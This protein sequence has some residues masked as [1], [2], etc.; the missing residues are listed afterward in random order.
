M[1]S[2]SGVHPIETLYQLLDHFGLYPLGVV[3]ITRHIEGTAFFPGGSGLW[4]H[5]QGLH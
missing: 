2:E 3:P 4:G 1:S 5:N